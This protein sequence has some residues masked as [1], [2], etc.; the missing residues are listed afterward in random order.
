MRDLVLD[1]LA[2]AG[3][4][5][6]GVVY[7]LVAWLA[8]ALALRDRHGTP[9]GQG[10]F[11]ELAHQPAGRWIL[12]LVAAALAGLAA[13]QAFTALRAADGWAARLGAAGRSLVLAVLAVLA[14][15]SALGDGSS[16]GGRQTPKGVTVRLLDLPVGPAIVV[17][18]GLF[19]AGIGVASA[20]RAFGDS[21]RDDLELDG[22]TGAS[23][24]LIAVLARSGFLCRAV[25]F[26]VIG[27][28]FVWA[29]I[30][31]DPKQSG[32]LDQ[33]IV[34]FRDEPYGRWVILVVAVGLGCYGGYNVVRA[35]YLR[36][37]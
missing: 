14:A 18:L 28:M 12:A 27:G 20:V 36:R 35:W 10:A 16:S 8:A 19:I 23:G 31:H 7:G 29:G 37:R 15:R 24:R 21:W 9:S 6:Y 5:A 33:A 13:Q 34:R 2:R 17:A 22:R 25:A 11:Q 26:A 30:T 1:R 32:G 3:L 4:V